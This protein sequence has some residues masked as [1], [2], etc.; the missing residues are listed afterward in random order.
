MS[1]CL[2]APC[3]HGTQI[4]TSLSREGDVLSNARSPSALAAACRRHKALWL[5]IQT[6]ARAGAI[7]L[8]PSLLA[9]LISAAHAVSQA[10]PSHLP[11]L[12]PRIRQD[13]CRMLAPQGERR[14]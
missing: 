1:A 14:A 13:V 3:V 12:L 5:A 6:A 2:S 8:P 10:T 9:H 7:A 4:V 11:A